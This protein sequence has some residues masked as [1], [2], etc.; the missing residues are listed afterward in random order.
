M[1]EKNDI[2]KEYWTLLYNLGCADVSKPEKSDADIPEN[3]IPEDVVINP[4]GNLVRCSQSLSSDKIQILNQ[5]KN[6]KL[7]ES[8]EQ[9]LKT[10]KTYIA[11]AF[12][13]SVSS[14][15]ILV[16]SAIIRLL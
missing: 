16:L 12:W 13:I 3:D 15:A 4:D 11:V 1:S 14:A 9:H 8:I 10:I 2:K 6:Q 5:I 7:L